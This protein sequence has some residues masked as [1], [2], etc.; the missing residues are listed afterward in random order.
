VPARRALVFNIVCFLA[1]GEIPC[2]QSRSLSNDY[3]TLLFTQISSNLLHAGFL[4]G[5]IL[6]C[7]DEGDKFIRNVGSHTN[8]TAIYIYIYIYIE[9]EREREREKVTLITCAERTSDTK[10][11]Y[12]I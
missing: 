3:C 7:E 8:Y 2:L 12:L 9:R 5:L 6:N 1:A 10:Y 4:L 11:L